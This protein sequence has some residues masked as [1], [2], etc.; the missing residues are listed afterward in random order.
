MGGVSLTQNANLT[1]LPPTSVTLDPSISPSSSDFETQV[2]I[3]DLETVIQSIT[4]LAT[5]WTNYAPSSSFS[6]TGRFFPLFYMPS[7]N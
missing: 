7:F 4:T 5:D 3:S 1:L 6:D 2:T